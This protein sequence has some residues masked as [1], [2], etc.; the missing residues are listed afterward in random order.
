M[1]WWATTL[2]ADFRTLTVSTLKCMHMLITQAAWTNPPKA[3]GPLNDH[4]KMADMFPRPFKVTNFDGELVDPF[5]TYGIWILNPI[6]RES[7]LDLNL[8]RILVRCL[9]AEPAD[10][11]SLRELL[12]WA[13]W[14]EAQQDWR[15]GQ[16]EIRAWSNEH[17]NQAPIVRASLKAMCP[18][19]RGF[20]QA[21]IVFAL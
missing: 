4:N 21:D 7:P 18:L 20:D 3:V 5:Y 19:P 2:K 14:R 15:A 1:L 8:G 9:A 12:R 11:P 13:R 10:R 6:A 17:I 16:E